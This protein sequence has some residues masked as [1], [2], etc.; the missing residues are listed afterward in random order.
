MSKPGISFGGGMSQPALPARPFPAAP[1]ELEALLAALHRNRITFEWK[2]F[3]LDHASMNR[4]LAPSSL[5]LA[6]LVKHMALVEDHYFTHQLLG[7]PYPDSWA[8]WSRTRTGTSS[9]HT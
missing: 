4:T 8:P 1:T 5:T 7:D 9:R 3:G 2:C 6:G